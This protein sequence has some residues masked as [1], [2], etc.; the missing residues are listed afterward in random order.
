MAFRRAVIVSFRLGGVD[1]VSVEAAKWAGALRRLG[2]EVTTVAGDGT[3][4][5]LV[6]GLGAWT[7]ASPDRVALSDALSGADLVVAEN[8]CSLPLN[9]AAS[10]AVAAALAGRPALLHHHDLP[11]QRPKPGWDGRDWPVPDDA[12]WRHVT[13]NDLSRLQLGERGITAVT[14]RNRFEIEPAPGDRNGTR[15]MLG[16]EPDD[17]VVLQPTRAIARK[18]VAGGLAVAEALGAVYWLT[19]AAEEDYASELEAVLGRA[20]VRVRRGPVAEMADAYAA[21]DL[22]VLPSSW[23]GFG[24]P[25][26][27]GWLH[28]RPVA[29]GSYPVADELRALG[30]EW[31]DAGAPSA[32]SG[33]LEDAA[34]LVEHNRAV[35]RRHLDVVDLPRRLAALLGEL[36]GPVLRSCN[37]PDRNDGSAAAPSGQP[38]G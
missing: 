7:A 24:N 38:S 9:R 1:G 36:G 27:E 37:G 14:E 8:I 26:V 22:V 16:I 32:L 30:F 4:D 20:T 29:V 21:S 6:P 28:G 13:V 34:A 11:W 10:D 33:R 5:V 2:L 17:R 12:H 3:A 15:R 23:E 25:A 18:N 31:L 35:A 19:G